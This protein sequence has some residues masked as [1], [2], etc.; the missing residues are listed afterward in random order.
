[1]GFANDL[2]SF[3]GKDDVLTLLIH[4]GYLAYD[5][6]KGTIRIP[7]EEIKREFQTSIHHIKLEETR[8]RI[9]ECEKLFNDAFNL[10]EKAVAEQI[11]KIHREETSPIHYNREASLRSV[12]KLA[13][14]TYRDHYLQFEELPSG[15]G[16]ADIV[17]LPLP[18]SDFPALLVELK[19]NESAQT[20]IDQIIE[21]KYPSGLKNYHGDILLAGINY[22]RK[23]KKH[24]CRII[25]HTM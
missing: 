3:R 4:L 6:E 13:Y 16:Y 5:K 25:E 21:K 8:K 12:I 20:A 10:N 1:M 22:D 7:N 11:E 24:T 14:F 9:E 18:S 23:D 17:Y 15:E 19:W 2:I